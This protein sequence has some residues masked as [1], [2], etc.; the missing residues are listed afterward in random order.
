MY[1]AAGPSGLLFILKHY[2]HLFRCPH[3][4]HQTIGFRVF[5]LDE[6]GTNW[7]ETK[8]LDDGILFLGMNSSVW[9]SSTNFKECKGNSIYF[10]YDDKFCLAYKNGRPG[11]SGVFHLEDRSFSSVFDNDFKKLYPYPLWVLPNP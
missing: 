5:K 3:S 1:L 4:R 8:N 2:K 11:D 7:V 6:T 9:V 10:A